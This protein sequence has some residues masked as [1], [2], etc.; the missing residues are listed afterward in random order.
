MP[1]HEPDYSNDERYDADWDQQEGDGED[2]GCR[3]KLPHGAAHDVP[4]FETPQPARNNWF[5]ELFQNGDDDGEKDVGDGGGENMRNVQGV[6]GTDV[7][8]QLQ[9]WIED[10]TP[11][12]FYTFVPN[13]INTYY[14]VWLCQF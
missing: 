1:T 12:M 9:F 2:A 8:T 3:A 7:E 11:C 14:D 6:G 13:F 5:D 10:L 4:H